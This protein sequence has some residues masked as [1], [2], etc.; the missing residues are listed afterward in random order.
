MVSLESQFTT[1]RRLDRGGEGMEPARYYFVEAELRPGKTVDLVVE[2]PASL[3]VTAG[4]LAVAGWADGIRPLGGF[5][6]GTDPVT[7][8]AGD[9]GST[10]VIGGPTEPGPSPQ[11]GVLPLSGYRVDKPWGFEVWYT[12]NLPSPNYALKQIHMREGFRSSLQSHEHK[13]ETNVIVEGG[14][15]VLNGMKAPQDPAARVDQEAIPADVAGPGFAWTSAPRVL[16]RVIA[17]HDYTA[18]EISTPEL[19]DVIRWSDDALRSSGR[20]ASEHGGAR[21]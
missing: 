14:A 5:H 15:R 10:M 2:G 20:I 7:L 13:A 9:Q 16:H 17:T 19:D 3:V 4:S 18:I 6:L 12:E 21:S 11:S 1:A 8:V